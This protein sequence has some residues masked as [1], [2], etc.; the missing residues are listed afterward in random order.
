MSLGPAANRPSPGNRS[1]NIRAE[2]I[3]LIDISRVQPLFEPADQLFGGAMRERVRD[4]VALRLRLNPVVADRAGR[5]VVRA[6]ILPY[7]IV[8]KDKSGHRRMSS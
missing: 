2:R 3:A 8:G 4:D 5:M 1:G 6:P 7:P